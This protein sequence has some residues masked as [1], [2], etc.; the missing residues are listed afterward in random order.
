MFQDFFSKNSAKTQVGAGLE[1][2]GG[3]DWCL[4]LVFAGGLSL[5]L[6]RA[7]FVLLHSQVSRELVGSGPRRRALRSG[8]QEEKVASNPAEI[9]DLC[10][11]CVVY[12]VC[13][14]RG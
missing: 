9:S 14:P 13:A 8:R 10:G 6:G 1:K 11:L 3:C 12:L 4:S 5:D 2:G 7:E